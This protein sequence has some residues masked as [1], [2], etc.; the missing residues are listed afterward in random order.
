MSHPELTA[1]VEHPELMCAR[2]HWTVKPYWLIVAQFPYLVMG[3]W[4]KG[5]W[6]LEEKATLLAKLVMLWQVVGCWVQYVTIVENYSQEGG[7]VWENYSRYAY[8]ICNSSAAQTLIQL[9]AQV[10][11]TNLF[12]E[13]LEVEGL[14]YLLDLVEKV[15]KDAPS[16]SVQVVYP[17][18]ASEGQKM[19]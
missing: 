4:A 7:T 18:A 8:L 15:E 17:R 9:L 19:A 16:R 1:L 14:E 11:A 10:T 2:Y 13:K 6:W 3:N 5:H 12:G